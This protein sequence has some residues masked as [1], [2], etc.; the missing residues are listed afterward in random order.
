MTLHK[1][2][3]TGSALARSRNVLTRAERMEKLEREKRWK[4]ADSIFGLPKVRAATKKVVK[5]KAKKKEEEAAA[6]AE[7]AAAVAAKAETKPA[8]KPA[9]K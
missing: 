2:L 1:S 5:K 9:K 3:K 7:G 4:E 8:A 6:P